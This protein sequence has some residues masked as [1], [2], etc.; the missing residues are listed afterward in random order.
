[1]RRQRIS[2]FGRANRHLSPPPSQRKR[3]ESARELHP[4]RKGAGRRAVPALRPCSWGADGSPEA[5]E[6]E[7][8]EGEAPPEPWIWLRVE[9]EAPPEPWIGYGPRG[10]H[11]CKDRERP[12]PLQTQERGADARVHSRY[13]LLV[14]LR[15][16]KARR[17]RQEPRHSDFGT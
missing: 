4:H 10:K 7:A 6:G 16:P 13:P 15:S 11:S 5:L 14:G 17:D 12:S 9:G 2:D 8:L 3:G 1:M